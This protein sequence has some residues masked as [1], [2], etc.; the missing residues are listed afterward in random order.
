MGTG[1]LEAR[2]KANIGAKISGLL[3]EV[4]ADQ[5]DR[6]KA[7]Q[8]LIKLDDRDVK[9]Q[10]ES[11]AASVAAAA[12]AV[13]RLLAERKRAGAILDQ[14]RREYDRLQQLRASDTA[15][16]VE[17][18]RATEALGIAEANV[19]SADAGITES[20]KQVDAAEKTL[21]FQRAKLADTIVLA[22]YDGLI[23]RRDRDPGSVVVPGTSVLTIVATDEMW[24]TAWVD[25]TEMARLKPGQ[26]ARVLFR[27]EPDTPYPGEVARLGRE[28]D[29]ETREFPVDVRVNKLPENWAVG[30]RAEVFI[31]VARNADTTIVPTRLLIWR[32]GKAGVFIDAQERA[33]WRA[34]KLGLKGR[35]SIEVLEGLE[36]GERIITPA[37]PT[38]IGLTEKRKVAV[39]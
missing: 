26:Q 8:P 12:A 27:S 19:G 35:E 11:A 20:R 6:V 9:Q 28:A 21:E 25:E 5:G 13:D 17:Y 33:Q 2:I 23:V 16:K 34:L 15:S 10:V 38:A 39:R 1:T 29:R 14:A 4:L 22:P 24:V 7:G 30:Q 32:D 36:P 18:D 3:T 37:D 31:E